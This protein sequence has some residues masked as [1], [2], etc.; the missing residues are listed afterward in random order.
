MICEGKR[1]ISVL[2]P[3][4]LGKTLIATMLAE[5]NVQ[6]IKRHYFGQIELLLKNNAKT[7]LKV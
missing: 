1:R 3:I 2:L 6:H 5:K 7:M 4:G